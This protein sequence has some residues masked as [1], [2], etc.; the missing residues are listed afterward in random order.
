MECGRR[1]DMTGFTNDLSN[2]IVAGYGCVKA[3]PFENRF[4]LEQTPDYY[5]RLE[6]SYDP[7]FYQQEA[8]GEYVNSRA[9]RVYHCFNQTIHVIE[10]GYEPHLPL[11][12]GMDFNVAPMS[13]VVMQK[14]GK[15]LVVIDEIILDRATTQDACEEFRNRYQG[16]AAAIEVFGDASGNIRILRERRIIRR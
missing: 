1:R 10:S 16:H 7:R 14:K 2:S 15:R 6:S 3:Q 5:E 8:L 9:D 11:M 4:L 12:W 13:S